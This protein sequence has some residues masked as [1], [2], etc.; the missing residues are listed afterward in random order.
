MLRG[1]THTAFDIGKD[2]NLT[3]KQI[4]FCELY[5]SLRRNYFGNGIE[6]AAEAYDIDISTPD[7]RR[8]ASQYASA[9]LR[10]DG[11]KLLCAMLL[12]LEGLNDQ[13][14]DKQLAFLIEQNEDKK[15]KI[16]AIKE[17]NAL[18]SRI[19]HSTELIV[20]HVFDYTALTDSELKTFIELAEKAKVN[21]TPRTGI[22][23]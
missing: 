14:V 1:G 19:K 12:E 6:A 18:N 9:A 23:L 8:T 5:T 22:A 20:K 15:S 17:Y 7:G 16:L 13:Q 10:S 3:P 4:T 11:V 21:D 2:L